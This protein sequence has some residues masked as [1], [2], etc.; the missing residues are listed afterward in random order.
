M[1]T[2]SRVGV[3]AFAA[4]LIAGCNS[5]DSGV[6]PSKLSFPANPTFPQQPVPTGLALAKPQ[7]CG[8]GA[9]AFWL[10]GP[11]DSLL[12]ANSYGS[13]EFAAVFLHEAGQLADMC[14]FWPYAKWLA[15][16]YHVRVVLFNR[17][18]Y[19]KS[20]CEVFQTGDS[21]IVSQVQPA[22][23]WARRH[24]TQTVTLVGASAGGA[25]ALQAGGV[26]QD[27]AAVVDLSG[28][29]AD[30]RANDRVD[31]RRLQVPVLFGIAPGDSIVSVDYIRGLYR[32]VPAGD[33]R[34]VIARR[35]VGAHGWDLLRDGLTGKFT[36][37]ARLVADW[38]TGD[39]H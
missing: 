5:S 4:L 27:V 11:H 37:L 26:V 28:E 18:T 19:G 34:L 17:C 7:P 12:E 2:W 38:V 6:D 36:P 16:R 39:R 14:G 20:T 25:D 35:S 10:P 1:S 24:G 29:S 22:V 3:V 32:S 33:E 9:H 8:H 23:D 31:A 30:T 21:G 15:D 13:G